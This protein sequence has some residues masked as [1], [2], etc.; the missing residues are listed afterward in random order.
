LTA[1]IIEQPPDTTA[2]TDLANTY[3]IKRLGIV[4]T[5]ITPTVIPTLRM[6][7]GV[8]VA[9]RDQRSLDR[10]V[11]L[12]RGDVIHAINGLRI[13]SIEGLRVV[14]NGV[15]INSDVVLQVERAGQLK[16]VT[17]RVF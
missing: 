1:R 12:I 10:T 3:P 17:L 16:F 8:L 4:A 15:K 6:P 13:K 11:P 14:L 7:F 2:L 9:A 5:D